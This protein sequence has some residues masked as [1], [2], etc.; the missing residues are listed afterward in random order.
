MARPLKK[1]LSYFPLDTDYLSDRKIQRL[2]QRYGCCGICVYVATLCEIYGENGYYV[3]YDTDF[4]FDLGFT[5]HLEESEVREIIGFCVQIHLFDSDLFEQR[6]VLTSGA[7]QRRYREV[8]RRS[9]P[10]I[11]A[12]LEIP[13][14]VPIEGVFAAE[15]GVIV[16]ETPVIATITP[17][18]DVITP[19]KGKGNKKEITL[20]NTYDEKSGKNRYASDE[21]AAGRQAELLRMAAAATANC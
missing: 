5:L 3:N 4:C 19:S 11:S 8:Y 20:N 21:G 13:D 2:S 10:R 12:E 17:V 15:T 16:T 18:S 7:V 1:G 6:R 9:Q 14:A